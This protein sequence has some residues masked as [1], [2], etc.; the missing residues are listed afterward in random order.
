[1]PAPEKGPS[2]PTEPGLPCLCRRA[3]PSCIPSTSPTW[4]CVAE[5]LEFGAGFDPRIDTLRGHRPASGVRLVRVP[6]IQACD[7]VC[8]TLPPREGGLHSRFIVS[9][10]MP[11]RSSFPCHRMC[12]GA[13]TL[14][15]FALCVFR[16]ADMIGIV[17]HVSFLPNQKKRKTGGPPVRPPAVLAASQSAI[18]YISCTAWSCMSYHSIS[19][20]ELYRSHP[21]LRSYSQA[22]QLHLIW[23]GSRLNPRVPAVNK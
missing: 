12:C 1:M 15:W 10:I 5:G 11:W 14:L 4:S 19:G 8:A 3:L 18:A 23:V 9:C 7:S 2:H 20:P 13:D 22:R 17:G 16:V 21:C 6:P